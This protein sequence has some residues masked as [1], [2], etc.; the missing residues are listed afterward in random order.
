MSSLIVVDISPVKT[1][2][3]IFSMA[4]LFD[5]MVAVSI[6]SGIAMSKARKLADEQLK[7][8]I[9]DVNLRNFLI[10]NLV[11]TNNGSYAWRVNIPAL[12][13]NFQQSIATFPASLKGL[14][15]AGPTLFIGGSL[16]DYIGYIYILLF[17]CLYKI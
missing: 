12:K 3:Q 7:P 9:P 1:S 15:Y 5:A 4:N 8:V 13:E 6:R 16:S 11:Q 10:T 14:Q 2:P 17:S